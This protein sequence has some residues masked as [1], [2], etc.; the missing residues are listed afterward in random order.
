[1]HKDLHEL[2]KEYHAFYEVLPYNILLT[3]K[4]GSLPA[5]NRT[6]Q[7]GFDVDIYGLNPKKDLALPG[8]DPNYTLAY[9]EL[10]KLAEKV[11]HEQSKDFCCL[12]VMSFPSKIVLGGSSLAEAQG[13]LRIRIS[14]HRG[15]D[16]PA[17]LP[18]QH[19]LKELEVQL[20][21]LGVVRR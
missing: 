19:V 16:R 17:D 2:A 8:P 14:H 1:M 10:Q 11:S 6:I 18:E 9:A 21:N 15:L 13:M 4:H 12:E 5:T 7:A 20:Q 3:E